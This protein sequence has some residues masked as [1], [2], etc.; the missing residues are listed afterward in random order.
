MEKNNEKTASVSTPLILLGI[1][2]GYINNP[3]RFLIKSKLS[4]R[5]FKKT[6]TLDLPEDFI[7]TYGF[8]AW[9]YIRLKNNLDQNKAFEIIRIALLT[10]GFAVQ[11]ANFKM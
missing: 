11:Q 5:K 8:V 6:I 1:L 7:N 3:I 9:L 10:S 4:F 2:K